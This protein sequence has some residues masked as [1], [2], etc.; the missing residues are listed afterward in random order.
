LKQT[1]VERCIYFFELKKI[2]ATFGSVFSFCFQKVLLS[3]EN[4][5]EKFST[6][7][8]SENVVISRG[9]S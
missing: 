9:F 8:G 4:Y 3:A 5:P 2:S 7:I 1:A 6:K